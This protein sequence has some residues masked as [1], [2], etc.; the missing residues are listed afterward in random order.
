MDINTWVARIAQVENLKGGF[1]I[2]C[3][4]AKNKNQHKGET[5]KFDKINFVLNVLSSEVVLKGKQNL[6]KLFIVD[7]I[8]D[9]QISEVEYKLQI[10][11]G[12]TATILVKDWATLEQ[13]GD[14]FTD[15]YIPTF[16]NKS[17]IELLVRIT[18]TDGNIYAMSH[19]LQGV[20]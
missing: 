8:A 6:I 19:N 7:S 18:D 13:L 17:T 16:T 5:M 3:P 9:T 4:Y 15:T 10:N 11:E 1:K 20:L 2:S 14:F 12:R